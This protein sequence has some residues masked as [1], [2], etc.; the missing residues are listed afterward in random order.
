MKNANLLSID[1]LKDKFTNIFKP[2]DNNIRKKSE[3]KSIFT[4]HEEEDNKVY[5][6]DYEDDDYDYDEDEENETEKDNITNEDEEYI[7]PYTICHRLYRK[8]DNIDLE[9]LSYVHCFKEKKKN[10]FLSFVKVNCIMLMYS[11]R[12][13]VV[14]MII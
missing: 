10:K 12:L 5:N 6:I 4:I 2:S 3:D 9:G 7:D 11:C 8:D 1:S 14:Y 13:E